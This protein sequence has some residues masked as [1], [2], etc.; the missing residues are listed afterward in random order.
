MSGNMPKI[1]VYNAL[2]LVLSN[3]IIARNGNCS[4]NLGRFVWIAE[5]AGFRRY[6]FFLAIRNII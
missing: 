3:V 4:I 1:T 5:R 2:N 6:D